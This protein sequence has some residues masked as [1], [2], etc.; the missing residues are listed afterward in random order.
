MASTTNMSSP[1][2]LSTL[3]QEKIN[4]LEKQVSALWELLSY[5]LQHQIEGLIMLRGEDWVSKT[6]PEDYQ[7]WLDDNKESEEEEAEEEESKGA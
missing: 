5:D 2:E 1:T 7:E 3:Q 4:Q 6:F